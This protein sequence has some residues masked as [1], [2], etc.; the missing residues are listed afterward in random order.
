M[1]RKLIPLIALALAASACG[2]IAE[3]IA[4]EAIERGLEAE[5]GGNVDIDLDSDGEGTIE[6]ESEEGDS[7]ISM[8]G[9]EVPDSLDMPIP[10]GY[11]VV[12]SS[13]FSGT[14]QTNTTVTLQYSPSDLDD[15]VEVYTDYFAGF[16][17]VF[18]SQSDSGGSQLWSW[19]TGDNDQTQSVAITVYDGDD[20]VTVSLTQTG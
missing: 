15:L 18:T 10:D 20:F 16:D 5:G 7:I 13:T 17:D 1:V 19:A 2:N 8:G 14:D 6:I 12:G 3:N 4:E 11:E 9:G